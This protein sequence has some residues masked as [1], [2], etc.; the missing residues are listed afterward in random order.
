E[1]KIREL[2]TLIAEAGLTDRVD[3]E[4][5]GGIGPDTIGAAAAAGA[6]ILVAGSALYRDPEGL[7]HA[8]GDLRARAEAAFIA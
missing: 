5:D 4:V 8:V 1:P 6:N 2:R 3:I 7:G